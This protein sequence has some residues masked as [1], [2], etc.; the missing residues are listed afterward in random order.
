MGT[1]A[2]RRN[3][4][5]VAADRRGD[6][7]YGPRTTRHRRL[8]Q[9]L[10]AQRA[11]LPRSIRAATWWPS[12][13]PIPR[14]PS[15]GPAQWGITPRIYTDYAAAARRFRR[16][17]PSSFSP[18]PIC[19][20]SRSSPRSPRA[21]TSPV[22]SRSPS[23]WPRPTA[24]PPRWRKARTTFRV[25]ENFLYY[26]PIVKAKEL[27]DAGAIG[28]PSLVRIHTTRAQ[29]IVGQALEL[30]PDAL[31]WRRDPGRN[32]GGALYDD[33]VHKYA[34]AMLLDRRDRRGLG[35]RRPR[36]GLPP[37][38]AERGHLALQGPRLPRASSTTPT[39]PR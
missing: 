5:T 21:S 28:E 32:P 39:R 26:P 16:S 37:G 18:P 8:R 13:T 29:E 17:T 3:C 1:R 36:R 19:T 22:R 15:G 30:D 10:P 11:R 20:P 4:G 7:R 27:L 2:G 25:T 33:G 24:S 9:H 12:A 34:T 38:D 35:H 23:A 14:G 6:P 31:V